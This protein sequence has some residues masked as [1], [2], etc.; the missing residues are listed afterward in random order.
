MSVFK[1]LNL[2]Y[3][4]IEALL[5]DIYQGDKMTSSGELL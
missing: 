3:Y 5:R 2:K 1:L 4:L